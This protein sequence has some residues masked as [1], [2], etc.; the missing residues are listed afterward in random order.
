MPGFVSVGYTPQTTD[1][2]VCRRHVN[3]VGPTGR[4]HSVKSAYFFADKIVSGNRIPDTIFY[5]KGRNWY[6]TFWCVPRLPCMQQHNLSRTQPRTMSDGDICSNDEK[7]GGFGAMMAN[8]LR[9]QEERQEEREQCAAR[10]LSVFV[11]KTAN[12]A[13]L[14]APAGKNPP[15]VTLINESK[16]SSRDSG[17]ANEL[18]WPLVRGARAV[19]G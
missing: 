3:N 8:S 18:P 7:Y 14:R 15:P 6:Y 9:C 4:R 1:I 16:T 19:W 13:A 17:V 11:T 12:V 5:V 10:S 2:C